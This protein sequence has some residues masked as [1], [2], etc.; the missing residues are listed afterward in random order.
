M[1]DSFATPWTVACQAPL[2]IAFWG[3]P[4]PSPGNR[5]DPGIES[6]SL[7]WQACSLLLDHQGSPYIMYSPLKSL[8]ITLIPFESNFQSC[9][10]RRKIIISLSLSL[11]VTHT[12]T[13][14]FIH[15]I[16]L[17]EHQLCLST[18]LDAVDNSYESKRHSLVP[19]RSF[20]PGYV[21]K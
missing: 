13:H 1:S 20:K 10:K 7:H 12:H 16:K 21:C 5:P 17:N 6:M 9:F 15:S 11:S 19:C 3:L 18:A 2:F 8:C 4:F 14:L